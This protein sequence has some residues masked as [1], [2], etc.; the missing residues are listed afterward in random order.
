MIHFDKLSAPDRFFVA[1]AWELPGGRLS[2]PVVCVGATGRDFNGV[3][4]TFPAE[5]AGAGG[6]FTAVGLRL[7]LEFTKLSSAVGDGVGI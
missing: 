4:M 7:A 1:W 6:M 3:L 5:E 2:E